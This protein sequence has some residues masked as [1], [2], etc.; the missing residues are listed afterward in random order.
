MSILKLSEGI[1][2]DTLENH[3]HPYKISIQSMVNNND[4]IDISQQYSKRAFKG[5][6]KKLTFYVSSRF[7]QF[8]NDTILECSDKSLNFLYYY[9]NNELSEDLQLELYKRV[10][11]DLESIKESDNGFIL[12]NNEKQKMKLGKLLSKISGILCKKVDNNEIENIVDKYKSWC[13]IHNENFE[14]EIYSSKDII[15]AY[16]EKNYSY[17][18]LKGMLHRSCMNDYIDTLGIYID[19]PEKI[20]LLVLKNK[21]DNKISGRA[22]IWNLDKPHRIFMD[23]VYGVDNF[24]FNIYEKL[25]IENKW[26]YR[27]QPSDK[28]YQV[29]FYH[30]EIKKYMTVN[31]DE[32]KMCVNNI[33]F[34]TLN[35]FPYVDSLYILDRLNNKLRNYLPNTTIYN[36]LSQ[37]HGRK[38][39]NKT[40]LFGI[41]RKSKNQ[42]I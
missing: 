13:G 5:I 18:G 37:I 4:Y 23:R 42:D 9:F 31:A 20:S 27:S 25:A 36:E 24:I 40:I 1:L 26:I 28:N 8:V 35:T 34:K 39:E 29:N 7:L 30:R 12:T 14:F 17:T 3:K 15:R 33:R 19:N 21:K 16:Q 10:F 11:R 22:L 38:P 6:Y 41:T 2:F 32:F